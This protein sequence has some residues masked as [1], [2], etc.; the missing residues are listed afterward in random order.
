[1]AASQGR[2]RGRG[3]PSQPKIDFTPAKQH[4]TPATQS[5]IPAKQSST[6]AT[7]SSTATANGSP[8]AE[9]N[10]NKAEGATNQPILDAIRNLKTD[11]CGRFDGVLTA[12]EG[13]RRE[14]GECLE[15]VKNTET[16]ISET[17]DVVSSLVARIRSLENK[18][19]DMEDKLEDLEARSR[20][21]NL[22]LVNL[23][24]GAE[25]ND[26]CSFLETWIPEALG[27]ASPNTKPILERAHR[28]GPRSD[29][30]APPRTLIMKFLN[31][32]DKT[33]VLN[34]VRNKKQVFYKDRAVRFYPDLTS[35]IHKKQ[36]AFDTARQKLRDMGIRNGMRFPAKLLLTHNGNTRSFDKPSD[37]EEFIRRIQEEGRRDE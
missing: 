3:K 25:G 32:R 16:R 22:R 21:S 18:N 29:P 14:V 35:G 33:R 13:V 19:R 37:V 8:M 11:F 36:K 12:I 20:R 9:E 26:A 4:S 7:Q 17:E 1:M 15:R 2:G 6:P 5:S 27:L 28:V 34:A 23:P 30:S 31:D 24:E 10:A